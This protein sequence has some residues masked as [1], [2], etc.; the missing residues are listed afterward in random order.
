MV[1]Q[2]PVFM[3]SCHRAMYILCL[4][5]FDLWGSCKR[6]I[7]GHMVY[8]I[9]YTVFG[10]YFNLSNKYIAV[11]W[12]LRMFPDFRILYKSPFASKFSWKKRSKYQGKKEVACV[13]SKPL[14]SCLW[15]CAESVNPPNLN[16]QDVR[17]ALSSIDHTKGRPRPTTHFWGFFTFVKSHPWYLHARWQ[18]S[19]TSTCE[20]VEH[21]LHGSAEGNHS[22]VLLVMLAKLLNSFLWI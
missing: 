11:L 12:F 9:K 1:S 22:G 3:V 16:I 18:N 4:A 6:D 19:Q 17:G 20:V 8:I 15:G 7:T 13:V 21:T 5:Q 2:I 10:C 14:V